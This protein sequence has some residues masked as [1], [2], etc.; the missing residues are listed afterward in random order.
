MSVV[1]LVLYLHFVLV[2]V[3]SQAAALQG[4]KCECPCDRSLIGCNGSFALDCKYMCDGWNDCGDWTDERNCVCPRGYYKCDCIATGC[5]GSENAAHKSVSACYNDVQR[6][7]GRKHCIDWSD[8]KGCNYS[9]PSES[10]HECDCNRKDG[11]C[12]PRSHYKPHCFHD[13]QKCDG[14]N[15]C[16]D[17]SDERRCTKPCPRNYVRCGCILN[18]NNCPSDGACINRR[19]VL[20]GNQ[21]CIDNSDQACE[22]NYYSWRC[23]D[24]EEYEQMLQINASFPNT[25]YG[26]RPVAFYDVAN[27]TQRTEWWCQQKYSSNKLIQCRNGELIHTTNLCSKYVQCTDGSDELHDVPGFKCV[28]EDEGTI[29]HHNKAYCVLP[30]INLYNNNS[31]CAGRADNCF[32]DGKLKCFQCLDGKLIISPK[33][34]CDGVVDCYDLSDECICEN[35]KV[36][37][38]VL[39]NSKGVCNQGTLFCNGTCMKA[40]SVLCNQSINCGDNYLKYCTSTQAEESSLDKILCRNH[41]HMLHAGTRCDGI[42]DCP[43]GRDLYCRQLCGH[44]TSIGYPHVSPMCLNKE[45]GCSS[46]YDEINCS[47]RFYCSNDSNS[48]KHI[49]PSQKCDGVVHCDNGIDELESLCGATRF[50][51][52]NKEPLSVSLDQVENGI[53]DCTDGSDECPANSNRTSIFSSPLEMIGNPFLRALFWIMGLLALFGNLA[54]FLVTIKQMVKPV[55]L[56]VKHACL[57]FVANLSL[58]DFLMSV[59]L[60]AVSIKGLQ[61]SSRYCYHDQE[62]RSSQLCSILGA[63]VVISTQAS[64]FILTAMTTFRLISTFNPF[65]TRAVSR[66][67]YIMPVLVFWCIAVIL[68]MFPLL[69]LNSVYFVTG[70][71]FPNYFFAKQKVGKAEMNEI[72]KT[73]SQLKSQYNYPIN[74]PDTKRLVAAT[75]QELDIKGE[76][77]YYGETSVCMPKLFV[78]V[79]EDTWEYSTFLI[80]LNFALFLYMV[81]SYIAIY[82]RS[83]S[84]QSKRSGSGQNK[85]MQ[86]K[87]TRLIVTDFCSWIPICTMAY[88]SLGGVE[89]NNIVYVISAAV[90]LPINSALNP[91]LYSN[92]VENVIKKLCKKRNK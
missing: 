88:I 89:M 92:V 45:W 85:K 49:S 16:G 84:M 59:Y 73:I 75:F 47:N 57:W 14:W 76:F 51:C 22:T 50:Y 13:V 4:V 15:N 24:K 18:R 81:F 21:N 86:K 6:C 3:Y 83:I 48:F 11:G 41:I 38:E 25:K 28:P 66:A 44:N 72:A 2:V 63:L 39:G 53:H 23:R 10:H 46:G 80:T 68:G 69:E 67:W 5:P 90:L 91:I 33:Q 30:Q 43:A 58:S 9:C 32:V 61:F 77:N 87:I 20:N 31:Y 74:W 71:W 1:K 37:N 64:A 36:C 35:K 65:L 78:K 52:L 56:P 27:A 17:W 55:N 70:V 7:D 29:T 34:V 54:V 62:W 26:C 12:A 19:Y 40:E 42:V 82:R 8:E 79:G 60:L